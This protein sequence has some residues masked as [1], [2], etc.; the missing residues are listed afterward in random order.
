MEAKKHNSQGKLSG[1]GK[2]KTQ[3]QP[4]LRS[5]TNGKGK[6]ATPNSAWASMMHARHSA[7]ESEP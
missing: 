6:L 5:L 4:D 2:D 3:E 7:N 1:G